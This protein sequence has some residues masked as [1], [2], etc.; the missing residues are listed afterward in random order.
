ML[1]LD[2]PIVKDLIK[3]ALIEDIGHGDLTANAF[4]TDDKNIAA[5]YNSRTNGIIAGIPVQQSQFPYIRISEIY[6]SY[7][8]AMNEAYAKGY[9]GKNIQGS[10]YDLEM[11]VPPG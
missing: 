7:A 9:L 1:S 6:L 5:K 4:I 2:S 10:G 3:Q 11:I 8:E